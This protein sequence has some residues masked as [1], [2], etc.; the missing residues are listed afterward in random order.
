MKDERRAEGAASLFHLSFPPFP[1]PSRGHL[2]PPDGRFP[3][4]CSLCKKP[5]GGPPNTLSPFLFFPPLLFSGPGGGPFGHRRR[6]AT[7]FTLPFFPPPFLFSFPPPFSL[8]NNGLGVRDHPFVLSLRP[9]STESPWV[10]EG[11]ASVL[12]PFFPP[13]SF[14]RQGQPHFHPLAHRQEGE[15]LLSFLPLPLS[16]REVRDEGDFDSTITSR[17]EAAM[18]ADRSLFPLLPSPLWGYVTL[19]PCCGAANRP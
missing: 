4:L 9:G 14:G 17:S 1:C 11:W 8:L 6:G 3:S 7:R 18:R 10:A 15:H 12:S 2:R 19:I 13:S 5:D 16:S